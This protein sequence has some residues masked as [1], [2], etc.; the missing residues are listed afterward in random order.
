MAHVGGPLSEERARALFTRLLAGQAP[1]YRAWRVLCPARGAP[2]PEADPR[3]SE[4]AEVIGHVALMR[5]EHDALELGFLVH[6][7]CWGHGY[8]AEAARAVLAHARSQPDHP[9]ILAT[10]DPDH[11]ASIRVLEKIGMRQDRVAHDD[12]G[13]YYIYAAT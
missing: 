4:Q 10:V 1:F 13:A 8:A 2:A 7:H 6:V 11:T 5:H 12:A 9:R 3:V